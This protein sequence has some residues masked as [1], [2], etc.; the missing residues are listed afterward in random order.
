M[1]SKSAARTFF[2]V[3][4]VLCSGVFVWLTIDSLAKVPELTKTVNLTPAAIRG[5]HLWEAKNCMGCHTLLGEGAY[6]APE[7]TMVYSRRGPEFI[8]A[9]LTDPQAVYP[10]QRRMQQ[11]D[12]TEQEKSDL[13]AFFKWIEGADLNGF[14]PAPTI[15]QVRGAPHSQDSTPLVFRQVCSACHAWGGQGGKVGPALDDVGK[16]FDAAYLR[17]WLK[18]PRSIRANTTMPQLPLTEAQITEL[19]AFFSP[20]PTPDTGT[21]PREGAAP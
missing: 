18:N 10:G 11:Y 21:A 2:V 3:G 17:R 19:I 13:I 16:R 14:P 7:L 20:T 1:L 15:N 9:M 12:L 5:K 4:T 6:Y 8:H